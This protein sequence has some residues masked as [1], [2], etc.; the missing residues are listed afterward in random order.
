MGR[1]MEG[2]WTDQRYDPSKSAGRFVREDSQ[3]RNW[4]TPDGEPGPSGEG[5]FKA[6]IG[7]YHLYV[8]L[9]CPWAHRT[10]IFRKLK[11]LEDLITVS[12]VHPHMLGNGWE[13]RQDDPTLSDELYGSDCL[14]Q[15]YTR[16]RPEY[17][18]R[19]TVPVL[20]DKLRET[21]VSNESSEIIR[22]LNSAFNDLTGNT[23]DFYPETLREGIDVLNKRIYATLNNGVY[24]CGFTTTQEA[25]EEAFTELF[26]TLD[27]LEDRLSGQRFLCG[28][29][30]TEA[31]WRLF[32]TLIRFDAVYHGHFKCNRNRI[33]DFPNLFGYVR[34]LYQHPGIRNTVDFWQIRQHYHY[35]HE[36][37]NP[38]RIIPK[39]PDLSP[40]DRPH[41]REQLSS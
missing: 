30:Q 39:G 37:I 5:G 38:Y 24:R 2:V 18:G 26:A 1:L 32:P 23:L 22:M 21:I 29:V 7:R 40:Y 34:D 9:A 35:S 14:H 16:A 17:T 28:N 4:I 12:V 3:L 10:L 31:D 25:Y 6:E 20:W 15:I 19:V 11:G 33:V 8:S 41:E 36:S 27:F 13:F